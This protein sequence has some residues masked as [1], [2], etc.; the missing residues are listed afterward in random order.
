MAGKKI[1]RKKKI[2]KPEEVETLTEQF[3]NFIK[4]NVRWVIAFCGMF[5]VISALMWAYVRYTN[6]RNEQAA[7]AYYISVKNYRSLDDNRLEE[8]LQ[9]FLKNYS[10]HPLTK[11][12]ALDEVALLI[13]K[14]KW[15]EAIKE[16]KKLLADIKHNSPL[17]P[18]A[19]KHLATAYKQKGDYKEALSLWKKLENIAPSEW[20][21]EIYWNEAL[22]LQKMDNDKEAVE[23]L[24]KALA[25]DGLLPDDFTI[26]LYLNRIS[27]KLA[28]NNSPTK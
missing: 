18:V 22:I 21:R 3:I 26:K 13:K 2:L 12:A 10:G 24:Q 6:S 15:D 17:Y 4:A 28:Q 27:H 5:L 16:C 19:L 25:A 7:Y 23:K 1:K 8:N 14:G 9:K 11:I 20:S